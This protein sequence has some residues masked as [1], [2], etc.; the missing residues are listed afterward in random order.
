MEIHS[1]GHVEIDPLQN[2]F[3]L[4]L[5]GSFEPQCF[6]LLVS[7]A[8]GYS[9]IAFAF[10]LKLPQIRTMMK[11]KTDEGLSY[12]STYLEI[13]TYYFMA[14]YAFHNKNPFSTYGENIVILIQ[15]LIILFLSWKYSSKVG[16]PFTR[17]C[18]V[19]S[20]LLFAGLCIQ[21][22]YIPNSIW[23]LIGS[24]PI[25]LGSAA[26][27]TQ[28]YHSWKTKSTGP[29]SIFTFGLNVMGCVARIF[30]TLTE[31]DDLLMLASCIN[32]T[33]LNLIVCIQIIIYGSKSKTEVQDADE[34]K[35]K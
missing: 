34:K 35:N 8:L 10:I 1:V 28:I 18:Y 25:P 14:L 30:T 16:C 9:I 29:L 17:T 3:N 32:G 13:F 15:T 2:C 20:L 12:T 4:F 33:I 11:T 31:T 24:S 5:K 19:L 6:Q 7:K 21:D 27:I 22:K 23:Y 26:R